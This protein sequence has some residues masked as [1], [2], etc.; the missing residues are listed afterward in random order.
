MEDK[1]LTTRRYR[2]E[3]YTFELCSNISWVTGE[4]YRYISCTTPENCFGYPDTVLLNTCYDF[5]LGRVITRAY[6][7]HRSLPLWILEKIK[8]VMIKLEEEYA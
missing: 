8:S 6:T 5:A 2:G 1:V 7:L 4:P 3:T